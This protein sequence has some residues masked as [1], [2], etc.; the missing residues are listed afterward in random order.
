[1][2]IDYSKYKVET[3]QINGFIFDISVE[4]PDGISFY[5]RVKCSPNN[6]NNESI[7]NHLLNKDTR[8]EWSIN[9]IKDKDIW[10]NTLDNV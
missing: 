7:I 4:T 6:L 9:L 5:N 2:E 8:K 10:I 1:M 3:K